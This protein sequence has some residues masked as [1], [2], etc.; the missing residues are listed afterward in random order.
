MNKLLV[1]LAVSFCFSNIANANEYECK[2]FV[3]DNPAGYNEPVATIKVQASSKSEAENQAEQYGKSTNWGEGS[4]NA[5][6][7]VKCW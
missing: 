6:S 3:R 2:I 1:V 7:E 5:Y 4:K